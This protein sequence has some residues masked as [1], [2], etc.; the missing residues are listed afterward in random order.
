MEHGKFKDAGMMRPDYSMEEPSTKKPK[1]KMEHPKVTIDAENF[2]S[3]KGMK[4]GNGCEL[5][6][7]VKKTGEDMHE[8]HEN[9]KEHKITFEIQKIAEPEDEYESLTKEDHE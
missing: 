9:K 8:D 7:K 6:M 2:P 5:K 3:L 4:V 1:M